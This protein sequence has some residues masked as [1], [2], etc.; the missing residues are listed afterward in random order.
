MHIIIIEN[1]FYLFGDKIEDYNK[2]FDEL[3]N[4]AEN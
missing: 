4:F 3:K 1:K 2:D